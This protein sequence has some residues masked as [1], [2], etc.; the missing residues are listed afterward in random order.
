MVIMCIHV[1]AMICKYNTLHCTVLMVECTVMVHTFWECLK[2]SKYASNWFMRTYM[3]VITCTCTR[4]V[5]VAIGMFV[6]CR[7]TLWYA[8]RQ[9]MS[10]E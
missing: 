2:A 7:E 1:C 3:L 8:E 10:A 9:Y 5:C 4:C 6:V